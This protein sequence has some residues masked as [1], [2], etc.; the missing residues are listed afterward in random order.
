MGKEQKTRRGKLMSEKVI[1]L[2]LSAMLFALCTAAAAQQVRKIPRIGYVSVSGSPNN[3]GVLVEAFRQGL[4]DLGYDE[5]KNIVVE[6]RWA[7]VE[8]ERVSAFVA[9]LVHSK[10][11]S[12]SAR[13]QQRSE[14]PN[15]L[16]R[17]S[18]S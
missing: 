12:W 14:P 13:V 11:M 10:W 3:P 1:G 17:Q 7:A 18:P 2:A 5:G 9:E 4:R 6:Y 16:L 15:R 8:P